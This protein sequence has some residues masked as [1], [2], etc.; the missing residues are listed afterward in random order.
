MRNYRTKNKMHVDIKHE[1]EKMAAALVSTVYWPSLIKDKNWVGDTLSTTMSAILPV[2]FDSSKWYHLLCSDKLKLEPHIE[3]HLICGIFIFDANL[4]KYALFA[5]APCSP[6]IT[7]HVLIHNFFHILL[8]STKLPG[9]LLTYCIL[10]HVSH[11]S[12]PFPTT[13]PS[14]FSI[15]VQQ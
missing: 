1:R 14:F 6:E 9:L 5:E 15:F 13:T 11:F 2:L 10:T 4:R 7:A 8:G 12:L 3:K